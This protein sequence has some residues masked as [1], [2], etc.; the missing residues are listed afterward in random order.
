[1]DNREQLRRITELTEQIAG[2]P[3]GYLSKKT[4]GGKVYYYHQWSENGVKQSRYLHDSEIA[5]LAD[6][7]E[8][9]KELQAQLRMLKS[10]KSRR[11]EATGM[12]CT[13]MHK[14]TP[15]AELELDDVTGHYTKNW[16]CLRT[17]A[18]CLSASLCETRSPTVRRLTTGGGIALFR[19]AA[20]VCGKHWN[21][22]GWQTPKCC[23][24]AATG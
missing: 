6:K 4:I 16:Q 13:F 7:I 1:M 22:W 20:A 3:K 18:S 23:S 2:L 9:R 19:Q 5:P 15:V 12:K 8:K 10:Q 11:N 24:S 14:R 21:R 17:G